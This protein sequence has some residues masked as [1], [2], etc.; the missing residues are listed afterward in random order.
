VWVNR[1]CATVGALGTAFTG[2]LSRLRIAKNRTTYFEPTG[3]EVF[4]E[5]SPHLE[6]AR[7]PAARPS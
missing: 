2:E 6:A 5:D 4:D 7:S 3:K 1:C